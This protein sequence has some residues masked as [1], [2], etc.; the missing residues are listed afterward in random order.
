MKVQW[1]NKKP[2]KSGYYWLRN[3]RFEGDSLVDTEPTI[4][5][6]IADKG[7]ST[8]E[9]TFCG[10]DMSWDLGELLEGEW[11]NQ[12]EPPKKAA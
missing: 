2:T 1:T 11:S 8:A 9:F 10:N 12:I 7:F 4:V 5:C 6:V 3:Y